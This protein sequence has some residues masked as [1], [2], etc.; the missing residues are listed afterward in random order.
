M[1]AVNLIIDGQNK[2]RAIDDKTRTELAVLLCTS[3]PSSE[4]WKNASNVIP[5][6]LLGV[7]TSEAH[8]NKSLEII[9]ETAKGEKRASYTFGQIARKIALA[10][11]VA[12]WQGT[13][14]LPATES[15]GERKTGERLVNVDDL[16]A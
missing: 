10:S 5:S 14:V 15:T 6:A 12:E 2:D 11:T 3:N 8:A 16:L 9:Q 13:I 7:F 1:N 4:A